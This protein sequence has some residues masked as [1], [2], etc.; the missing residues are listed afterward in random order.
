MVRK[1]HFDRSDFDECDVSG[2]RKGVTYH[3][4][5]SGTEDL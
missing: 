3:G 5:E 1:R 4:V 2:T